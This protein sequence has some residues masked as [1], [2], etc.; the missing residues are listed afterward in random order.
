MWAES[1]NGNHSDRN[2]SKA[3]GQVTMEDKQAVEIYLRHIK[4]KA[5]VHF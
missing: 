2:A 5:K 1:N 4:I 3:G